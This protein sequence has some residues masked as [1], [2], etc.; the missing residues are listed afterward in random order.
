MQLVDGSM[1]SD[2]NQDAGIGIN[3][4]W[5]RLTGTNELLA[6][7]QAGDYTSLGVISGQVKIRV[8]AS[9][10]THTYKVMVDDVIIQ[11][12][13][14]FDNQVSL[15]TVRIF[16]DALNEINFS[17]RCFDN[18]SI[19][20]G[21]ASW[22]EP[23]IF[24]SPAAQAGLWQPF[25]YDVDASGD[26]APVYS[27]LSSPLGMSID[28]VSGLISWIPGVTGTIPVSVRAVNSAG[29]AIQS[30]DIEASGLPQFTCSL[31][32]NVMPLGDSIT[33]GKSSGV[34]DLSKQISFRKDL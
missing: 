3:L 34:D 33:V 17:G 30:F 15:N 16:T 21:A 28:P 18:L 12:G 27:L 26:P 13:I 5:T 8:E 24:S 29:V 7:R 31:L 22:I 14:P 4:V 23:A 19:Q 25:S 6:Y 9:L 10:E 11:A 1:M 32:V 2:P 20:S